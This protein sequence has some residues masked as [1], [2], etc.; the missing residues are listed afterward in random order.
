MELKL[1]KKPKGAKI[2]EGFPGLGFIGSIATEF[3]VDHLNCEKIGS[4]RI[5]SAPAM[6]AIHDGKIIEPVSLYYSKKHNVV[7]VHA[8]AP[9]G[10]G[11]EMADMIVKLAQELHSEEIICLEGVSSLK[12]NDEKVFH[13][14][15]RTTSKNKIGVPKLSEGV[16]VGVTGALL[17][18]DSAIPVTSFFAETHMK[19]PDSAAAAKLLAAVG[20]YLGWGVDV[21]PL[22]ERAKELE[23]KIKK[24]MQQ[25]AQTQEL[26]EVKGNVS[27]IG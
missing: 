18:T 15:T 1:T 11:W 6:I 2:L 10:Q 5:A 16:I 26:Q 17:A 20:D 3:L 22:Y 21:A 12:P 4:V 8:L 7:L 27:Y 23:V 25:K 24:I 13:Y 19:L 14:S 9:I